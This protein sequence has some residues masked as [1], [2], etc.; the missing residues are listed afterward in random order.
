[1][2]L[3]SLASPFAVVA[4]FLILSRHLLALIAAVL[5]LVQEAVELGFK[6]RQTLVL[7][8]QRGTKSLH[9]LV[10]VIRIYVGGEGH[11]LVLGRILALHVVLR[12]L[13]GIVGNFKREHDAGVHE[14]GKVLVGLGPRC[15]I[16]PHLGQLVDMAL[17]Q[18]CAQERHNVAVS[19]KFAIKVLPKR[20]VTRSK[21]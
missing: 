12:A 7:V 6:C 14:I 4:F 16:F 21:S 5:C 10:L 15:L 2:P 17:T 11:T 9:F 18:A 13:D 3:E 8:L 20:S 1:M 19:L